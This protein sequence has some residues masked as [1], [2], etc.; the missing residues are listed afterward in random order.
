MGLL[1]RSQTPAAQAA[2]NQPIQP[3]VN[4]IAPQA[5]GSSKPAVSGVERMKHNIII[6][7]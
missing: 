1:T 6:K 5:S 4:F 7:T 3:A 2:V